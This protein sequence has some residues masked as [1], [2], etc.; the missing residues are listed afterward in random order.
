MH[1]GGAGEDGVGDPDRAEGAD[2]IADG[3]TAVGEQGSGAAPEQRNGQREDRPE[4]GPD[5]V[6]VAVEDRIDEHR[7]GDYGAARTRSETVLGKTA[8]SA[9]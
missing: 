4:K 9:A 2:L 5:L 3:E 7:R 6:P 8:H 1:G